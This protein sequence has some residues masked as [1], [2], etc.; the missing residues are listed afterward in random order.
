MPNTKTDHYKVKV[1]LVK[2][3]QHR[4]T[5]VEVGILDFLESQVVVEIIVHSDLLLASD[6]QFF[7]GAR[8]CRLDAMFQF[9]VD[10]TNNVLEDVLVR[11]PE[12]HEEHGGHDKVSHEQPGEISEQRG[13][14][15]VFII[16]LE[17]YN[18]IDV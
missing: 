11:E 8:P 13:T 14:R 1:I 3:L 5:V 9:F 18:L 10:L 7:H 17:T 6:V 15:G 12:V 4:C 16:D 2:D